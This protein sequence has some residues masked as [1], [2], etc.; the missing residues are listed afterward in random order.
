MGLNL[1]SET[2]HATVG[3]L[4]YVWTDI[5][6]NYVDEEISFYDMQ[7]T[8]YVNVKRED[9]LTKNIGDKERTDRQ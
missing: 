7:M 5:C 4:L 8:R 6:C 1:W 9:V 2:V 3:D